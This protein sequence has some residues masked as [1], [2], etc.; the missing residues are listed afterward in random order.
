M[1]PDEQAM[2]RALA[3]QVRMLHTDNQDLRHRLGVLEQLQAMAE[4]AIR[5]IHNRLLFTE[6]VDAAE[7]NKAIQR[8]EKH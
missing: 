4:R 3:L 2:L 6:F 1:T 7:E 5:N 8:G